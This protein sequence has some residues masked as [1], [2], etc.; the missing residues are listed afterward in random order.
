FYA[1]PNAARITINDWLAKQTE[2]SI[3]NL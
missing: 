2:D 1:D 3:K